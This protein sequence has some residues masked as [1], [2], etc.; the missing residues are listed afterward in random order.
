MCPFCQG[1]SYN[2]DPLLNLLLSI[3]GKVNI[4]FGRE[5][6][7]DINIKVIFSG[8]AKGTEDMMPDFPSSRTPINLEENH[9]RI[10]YLVQNPLRPFS[11]EEVKD[12]RPTG[13]FTTV[14]GINSNYLAYN[15]RN[16]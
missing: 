8:I 9:N 3:R 11:S 10:L 6:Q 7:Q 14:L 16:W 15:G 13:N 4:A 5:E 1:M 12:G 2:N